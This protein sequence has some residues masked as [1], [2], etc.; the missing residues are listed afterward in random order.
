MH[1][2]SGVMIPTRIIPNTAV[3][4][5]VA[6]VNIRHQIRQIIRPTLVNHSSGRRIHQ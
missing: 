1:V 5:A 6:I 3:T 4:I 2:I